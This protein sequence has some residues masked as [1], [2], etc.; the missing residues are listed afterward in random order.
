MVTAALTTMVL[1]H[2]WLARHTSSEGS[3]YAEGQATERAYAA[4][5]LD[6][7]T[8]RAANDERELGQSAGEVSC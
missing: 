7:L 3:N 8:P 2:P 4:F 1:V 6:V 5:W